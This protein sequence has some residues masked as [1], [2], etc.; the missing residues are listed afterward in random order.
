MLAWEIDYWRWMSGSS[1]SRLSR[2]MLWRSP[3][4]ALSKSDGV[5]MCGNRAIE[6]RMFD[7][8]VKMQDSLVNLQKC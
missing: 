8:E 1:G 6:D 7:A 4:I 3:Y 2:M 5:K